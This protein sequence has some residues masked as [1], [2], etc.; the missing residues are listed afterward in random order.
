MSRSRKKTPKVGEKYTDHEG[1]K[2]TI[3]EV[4]IDCPFRRQVRG[5]IRFPKRLVD[6]M[7]FRYK[8]G[9]DYTP[10][11]EDWQ[12]VSYSYRK[13]YDYSCDLSIWQHIWRDKDAPVDSRLMKIG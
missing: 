12:H 7:S 10:Q 8:G 9:Y 13:E 1:R 11:T 2:L 4:V 3:L 6:K 5:K